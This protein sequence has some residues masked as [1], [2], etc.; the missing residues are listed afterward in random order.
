MHRTC[1]RNCRTSRTHR[2]LPVLLAGLAALALPSSA[3]IAAA[4]QAAAADTRYERV[5]PSPDGI[6]KRYMG[7]EIAG[8]MGWEGA[9]WLERESRAREERPELLLRELALAPGMTVADIGAGTGYYTWQL[10]KRVGPGGRVYAVDVQPEMIRMLDSQM[11]KRGV[12][13]VVSVLGSETSVKLPPASVDLAIMVDVY[14]EL[15]YPAEVLD[16]IVD[17]LK[18]GGRVVFIEYRA[19]DPAVAI[20]PL[21][22]MSERQ[23]RREATA[24]GLTWERSIESLPIQHAIVFR[25]P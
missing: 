21:H 2:M 15:A 13:N 4:P 23:V 17:A 20:K 24:H 18:P 1:P 9:Q 7:R 14:H 25:K 11:A 8:V 12:R 22:K 6:G 3:R 10:A 5:V 16:S 19:E